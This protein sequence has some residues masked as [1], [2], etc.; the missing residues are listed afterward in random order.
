MY[1]PRLRR[2][3]RIYASTC[4]KNELSVLILSIHGKSI[5]MG[6]ELKRGQ[7]YLQHAGLLC[8]T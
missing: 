4:I 2:I 7:I 8:V 3:N 5:L 6:D 1:I